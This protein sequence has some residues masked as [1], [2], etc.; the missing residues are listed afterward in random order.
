MLLAGKNKKKRAEG[1]KI[2]MNRDLTYGKP[3]KV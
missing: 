2:E 3:G 1:K